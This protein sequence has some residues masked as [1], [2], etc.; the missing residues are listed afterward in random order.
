[1]VTGLHDK[2][3]VVLAEIEADSGGAID[4]YS[5]LGLLEADISPDVGEK[6]FVDRLFHGETHQCCRPL[7][8]LRKLANV[9]QFRRGKHFV[10]DISWAA[11][12]VFEVNPDE[13]V[14]F[15]CG[16]RDGQVLL[17]AHGSGVD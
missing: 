8:V 3:A 13:A 7:E 17:V 14:L 10:S 6:R 11:C 15:F 16:Y 4:V 9:C 1:V 12:S 5:D 2:T